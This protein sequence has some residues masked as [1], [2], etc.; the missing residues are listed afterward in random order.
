MPSANKYSPSRDAF[1][2]VEIMIVVVIIGLFA[3]I[4]IPA[5][6]KARINSYATRLANDWRVFS[7]AFET[8]AFVTGQWASDG[9]GNNLPTTMQPYL[10]STA[11]NKPAPNGGVWDW[12]YNRLG[13]TAGI[14]LTEERDMP[15]LFTRVDELLDDGDL[16][17]GYF[18]KTEYRYLLILER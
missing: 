17:T 4:A 5:F 2:L 8:H 14:A 16:S 7:G 10:E 6:Q 18:I 1:T 12:E 13:V 3:A 11:W 9:S 15:G